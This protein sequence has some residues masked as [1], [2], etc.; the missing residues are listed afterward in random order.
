[1]LPLNKI[2]GGFVGAACGGTYTNTWTVTDAC[3]N[4]STVFTQVI[5]IIDAI[6]PIISAAGADATINCPDTPVFT[7]PTAT[8][9]CGTATVNELSDTITA[10]NPTCP[11]NYSRTKTWDATDA[12][13]NHSLVRS[14]TITVHDIIAPVFESLPGP[15]TIA[16][17]TTPLFQEAVA[18]DTCS[19]VTLTYIDVA[20]TPNCDGSY[21]ITRNWTAKDLCDNTSTAS[22]VINIS[23]AVVVANSDIGTSVNGYAGGTSFTNV[24]ANDTLNGVAVIPAQVNTTFM[25]SSNS[26]VMLSGTNVVVAAG[27]PAGSYTLTYQICGV[28]ATCSCDQATVSVPVSAVAIDAVNDTGN[29]VLT[30][31]GG[32]SFANVLI[33]DTLNGDPATLSNVILSQSSTTNPGVTLNPLDGSIN[34]TS[35]TLG[36]NYF[37]TYEICE[38]L[39]PLNC[40]TAI[41]SVF[42]EAPSIALV[43]TGVFGDTNADGYAQV[44]EKINYTFAVTNTGNVTISNTVISDPLFGLILSG[45]PIAS[46]APG[47]TGNVTGVYTLTQADID[48]GKVTNSALATGKDPNGNEV[49]DTS[50]TTVE[51]D[52]P[53][54][55][56]LPQEPKLTVT[57]TANRDEYSFV[58]DIINYTIKLQNT[59]NAT[60]HDVVVTDL[61]TGLNTAT[62]G[63]AIPILLAGESLEFNL[64]NSIHTSYIITKEDLVEGKVTNIVA[65]KGFAPNGNEVKD[66]Y[67]LV[68]EKGTVLGCGTIIVHNAFSP[69]N[70]GINEVFTIESID[71]PCYPNNTVEIYNR[72][73]VLVFETQNY[74]NESNFFDGISRGRT[75]I[76][77]SSGLPTGT[78]YYILNYTSVDLNGDINS[79]KKAGYLFLSR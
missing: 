71:D 1:M 73:G 48:A 50:G 18:T 15:T 74:N 36:G 24:L 70:D 39:N 45:N 21:S 68:I 52:T 9:E 64:S 12:C 38:I 6:A 49:T 51:N 28:S 72:W 14:Q 65:A 11:G 76:K 46:L 78:Y 26:G 47:I 69:N 34:V 75:T 60:L 4:T 30:G 17:N 8:D 3:N 33:N 57:K 67:T 5:N 79:N 19:S 20:T 7:P 2:S 27:T 22:Q 42:V 37:V 23:A 66:I 58:G 59:G 55:I 56:I 35:D 63:P 10:G 32:Q 62:Q 40:D 44:G 61:L 41:V 29:P 54:I 53:T 77:Q 16:N 13:G 31:V 25:S 43:K